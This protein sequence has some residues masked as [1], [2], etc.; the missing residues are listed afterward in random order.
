MCNKAVKTYPSTIKLIPECF[1]TQKM[2][3]KAINR[4]FFVFDFISD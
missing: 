2:C 1:M 3:G 4:C